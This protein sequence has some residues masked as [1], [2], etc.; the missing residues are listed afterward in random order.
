M[1]CLRRENNIIHGAQ[2]QFMKL[3]FNSRA[4]PNS[5]DVVGRDALIPPQ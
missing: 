3:S 4:Q 1:N 2:R 5:S